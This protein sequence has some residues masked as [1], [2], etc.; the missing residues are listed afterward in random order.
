MTLICIL[1]I[2][3]IPN[4]IVT[5]AVAWANLTIVHLFSMFYCSSASG[6]KS[7]GVGTTDLPL[8]GNKLE[9]VF[10]FFTMQRKYEVLQDSFRSTEPLRP[11]Y[12]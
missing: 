10:F 4:G 5:I 3:W 6:L 9:V 2:L 11:I 7:Q 8:G 12:E 1:Y